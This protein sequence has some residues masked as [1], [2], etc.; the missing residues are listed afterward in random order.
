M[1]ITRSAIPSISAALVSRFQ[2]VEALASR[3]SSSSCSI[4]VCGS[5]TLRGVSSSRWTSS[6]RC[7]VLSTPQLGKRRCRFLSFAPSRRGQAVPRRPVVVKLELL[8]PPWS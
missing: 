5:A 8:Q 3:R 4:Y 1:S 6:N 7:T 2:E